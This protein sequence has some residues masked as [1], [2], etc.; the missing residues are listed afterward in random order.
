MMKSRKKA[1]RGNRGYNAQAI[2][3]IGFRRKIDRQAEWCRLKYRYTQYK[4][5]VLS[6]SKI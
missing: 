5:A 1:G 3:V 4:E 6:I 2:G